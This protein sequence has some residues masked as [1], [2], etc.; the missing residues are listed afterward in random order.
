MRPS[1]SLDGFLQLH[2]DMESIVASP[3]V[4]PSGATVHASDVYASVALLL[5]G[6]TSGGARL[7]RNQ[8]SWTLQVFNGTYVDF[9][10]LH[11]DKTDAG[12]EKSNMRRCGFQHEQV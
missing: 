3:L 5:D 12:L 2:P 9:T 8:K 1:E 6:K 11:G 4:H 10:C 7:T